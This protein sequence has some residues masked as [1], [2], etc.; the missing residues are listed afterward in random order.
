MDQI[1]S[2]F[3]ITR[4]AHYQKCQLE[5]VRSVE[6]EI[7]LEMVRL[8]RRRHP[9]M[10]CRKVLYKI[11]PML[12]T[13]DLNI[14]RDRLFELLREANLLV[15]PKKQ[16]RRTTIPGMWRVP[17]RLSGLIVSHCN[18]VWVCDITYLALMR[19]RFAYM[20][21]LMDLYSRYIVGWH[22]SPSLAADGALTSLEM[23]L[24]TRPH[25][26]TGVIHHSDRGAQYTSRVYM[27]TL[28]KNELLASMGAVGNCYDNIYAERVIGILKGEYGLDTPFVNLTQVIS[29]VQEVIDSYNTDRPHLSLGMATPKDVYDGKTVDVPAIDI[30]SAI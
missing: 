24:S 19:N 16:Y 29:F 5:A 28:L 3:G 27:Q 22:V 11:R 26:P 18:Q 4:Q 20:F 1:C 25:K 6:N 23:A 2:Q 15:K 30:P 21:V 8:I 13:E 14:G 7:I 10:G 9:R 17:N 12:A